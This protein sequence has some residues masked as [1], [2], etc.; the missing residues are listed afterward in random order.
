M[1]KREESLHKAIALYEQGYT[2]KDIAKILGVSEQTLSQW[3]SDCEDTQLDWDE[4]KRKAEQNKKSVSSW[5]EDQIQT[6][7]VKIENDSDDEDSLSRLDKFISMK[8]KYDGSIDK[9]GETMRVM[10]AFASFVREN[11]PDEGDV[12]KEIT[13]SFMRYIQH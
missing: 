8:K 10:E 1:G 9:L 13:N 6:T 7:M 4:K 2:Q 5:L 3:K 11:F 12:V